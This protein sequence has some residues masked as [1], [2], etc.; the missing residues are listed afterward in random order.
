VPRIIPGRIVY[1]REAVPDPQGKNPKQRR[2]F[3]VVATPHEIEANDSLHVV[4]ITST[5]KGLPEEV[6]LAWGPNC[7]TGCTKRSVAL[8]SWVVLLSKDQLEV[9]MHFVKPPQL[10][11]IFKKA[12]DA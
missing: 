10:V 3:I 8:C 6:K 7:S 1:S 2:K 9:T 11:E 12:R 5:V 4:G